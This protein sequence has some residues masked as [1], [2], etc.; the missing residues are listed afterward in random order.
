MISNY[1]NLSDALIKWCN[2]STDNKDFIDQ[3]PNFIFLAE[4]QIFIDCQTIHNQ[5]YVTFSLNSGGSSINK[6]ADFGRTLSIYLSSSKSESFSIVERVTFE[7]GISFSKNKDVG[8]PKYYT[9]YAENTITLFPVPDKKYEAVLT[10][11][12]KSSPS[13]SG[14]SSSVTLTYNPDIL[15][16][17]A[18]AKAFAYLK[19]KDSSSFYDA[20]YKERIAAALTYD[21]NSLVDRNVTAKITND[22]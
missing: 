9:D 13:S 11:Y 17:C 21:K 19:D 12:A 4:Q 3:I 20:L 1:T 7:R 6:P 2:R 22:F 18:L 10:Y 14:G 16:Y 8:K 5:K 15:F